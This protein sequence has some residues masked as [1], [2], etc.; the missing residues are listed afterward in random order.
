MP[1]EPTT[2]LDALR[3]RLENDPD[4]PYLDFAGE[5]F[6][7]GDIDRLSNRCSHALAD[8][9]VGAGDRVASLLDNVPEQVV[10]FFATLK[11]GAIAV[12]V[13]TAY[14]GEFL[15]HQLTDSG[16]AVMVVA[17]DRADRLAG[18]GSGDLPDL[19]A[20]FVVADSSG[21]GA[22]DSAPD[23]IPDAAAD[24]G[25]I[26]VHDW[27]AALDAASDD[28]PRGVDV[29]PSDLACLVYTAGT[30]GPSKGCMLPHNYVVGLGDQVAR[31]WKRRSDDVVWTPLPLFHFNAIAICVVGTLIVGGSAAIAR[32]FSVSGF[33]EEVRRT[34]ATILSLLGPVALMVQ[35][36]TGPDDAVGHSVRLMAAAPLAPETD[37]YWREEIGTDTFSAGFGLTEASLLAVLPAGETNTP[38]AAG[39]V[40]TDDF[41]VRI[42]DDGDNDVASGEV[43]E[44]VARPR[45]PHS[46][47]AGYWRR[48][49]AWTSVTSNLWF[50]TGDLCRI[51]DETNL[52]FVDRKKDYLRRRGENISSFELEKT[53]LAH[54]SLRDVAVHAVASDLGEDDVKVTA[55]LE[56]D[57]DLDEEALC[58]WS[59]QRLPYF[60]VPRYV[61]FRSELPRNPVGRVLKYALRDEGVT[62]ATWDREKAGVELER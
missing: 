29:R 11:L 1:R 7:A 2:V 62:E 58:R 60:A 16:A 37:R 18:L 17:S 46:M 44:L 38:G 39:K 19:S 33:W 15:R 14:K 36:A 57:A 47:F 61:E 45:L 49:E 9:G 52:F 6:S 13:N 56:E 50:H 27:V 20:A 55:V 43:G 3:A 41:D 26:A 21:N 32:R 5:V 34:N 30:T 28:P 4:G 25:G 54:E 12:P 42:V 53:F 24:L 22:S 35:T 23:G 59:A 48:P 31:A 8:L 40:N 10:T 51:D